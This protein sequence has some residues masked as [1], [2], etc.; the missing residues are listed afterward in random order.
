MSSEWCWVSVDPCAAYFCRCAMGGCVA[1]YNGEV[2]RAAEEGEEKK[3][4]KKSE[5]REGEM[6][7]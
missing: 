1:S 7:K 3:G 2:R 6:Y 5:R 4:L